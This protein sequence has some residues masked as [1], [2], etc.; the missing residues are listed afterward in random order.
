LLREAPSA[1]RGRGRY[2]RNSGINL[3]LVEGK[4]R[5]DS[6][7]PG[8]LRGGRRI[9]FAVSVGDGYTVADVWKGFRELKTLGLI[10]R[11]PRIPGVQAAGAAPI[12]AVFLTG[13]LRGGRRIGLPSPWAMAVPWQAFGRDSAN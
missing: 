7:S 9:G 6:D 11:T 12:T 8:N 1:E 5:P 10:E 4:K 13:N 2:N 3:Y